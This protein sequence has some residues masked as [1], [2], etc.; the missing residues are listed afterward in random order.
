MNFMDKVDRLDAF[1]AIKTTLAVFSGGG[2]DRGY[3]PN[4][5][6]RRTLFW[7]QVKSSRLIQLRQ[8]LPT[9]C[10]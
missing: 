7:P 6:E 1:A 8:A 4:A 2:L 9:H 10:I 5:G 3:K